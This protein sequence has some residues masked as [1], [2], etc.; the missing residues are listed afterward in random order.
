MMVSP[1]QLLGGPELK[2]RREDSFSEGSVLDHA[3][4]DGSDGDNTK[5]QQTT[6]A[7]T[8]VY[9]MQRVKTTEDNRIQSGVRV[10]TS[11]VIAF[12]WHSLAAAVVGA[13]VWQSM[14]HHRGTGELYLAGMYGAGGATGATAIAATAVPFATINI[15]SVTE[16]GV[17]GT[18][19]GGT[20]VTLSGPIRPSVACQ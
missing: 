1:R 8:A 14:V 16:C 13:L 20:G 2:R 18:V 19:W 17:V 10:L 9:N 7:A 11:G 15:I 6:K 12:V 5:V 3:N 4:G